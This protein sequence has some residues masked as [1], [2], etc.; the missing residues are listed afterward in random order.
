[1][2][3]VK[4]TV[5][6]MLLYFVVFALL[7]ATCGTIWPGM[8]NKWY[9]IGGLAIFLTALEYHMATSRDPACQC[10]DRTHLEKIRTRLQS[11][12][13]KCTDREV[14]NLVF[15]RRVHLLYWD[16]ARLTVKHDCLLL[17]MPERD[18]DQFTEW[19]VQYNS[20]KQEGI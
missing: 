5:L 11:I 9:V 6:R 1:M 8:L 7:I 17:E 13:Y 2:N 19:A 4:Y 16:V 14:D 3:L 20:H 15:L 18:L 10:L 12:G